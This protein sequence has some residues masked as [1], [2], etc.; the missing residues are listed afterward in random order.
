MTTLLQKSMN[1]CCW[2]AA[3]VFCIC[4]GT[5]GKK[6]TISN[7]HIDLLTLDIKK[8]VNAVSKT[9]SLRVPTPQK[10]RRYGRDRVE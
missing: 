7:V 4:C 8:M 1:T 10:A 3:D 5:A 6:T 2:T 9:T